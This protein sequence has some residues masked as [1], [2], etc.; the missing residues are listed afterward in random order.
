MLGELTAR[1]SHA[2]GPIA[3]VFALII[4]ASVI[5]VVRGTERRGFLFFQPGVEVYL[6]RWAM[7]V[8]L[9]RKAK[10]RTVQL[11]VVCGGGD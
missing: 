2:P 9:T 5:P 7:L 6:G 8:R 10:C 4:V 11:P 1:C 3:A